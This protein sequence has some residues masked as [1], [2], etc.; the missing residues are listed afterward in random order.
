MRRIFAALLCLC[1]LPLPARA[2]EGE[3]Y[4]ALTFD[5]GPS[6]R[7]TR[8]LL[9]GLRQRGIRATFFLCGYRME[10]FPELTEQ[11]FREGHEIGCHGFSHSDMRPMSRREVAGE[12]GKMRELLPDGCSL[13]FLRPPGGGCSDAVAQVAQAQGLSIL[14]WSVDP[15]DWATRDT[16]A[17]ERN[18]LEQ[19]KD[20]DVILLHDMSDSSVQ[21]ALAIVDTL[22]ERG[23]TFVTASDLAR[24]RGMRLRP[25]QV[26]TAFPPEEK[27]ADQTGKA[28]V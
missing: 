11:I 15:R 1:L 17:V 8:T 14:T 27:E 23:F 25:G 28:P 22:L 2:R 16:W 18:V 26:Y 24:L 20:G 21:A 7:F 3:K 12:I 5:D 19:V 10:E 9:K 6:G 13:R 4:V